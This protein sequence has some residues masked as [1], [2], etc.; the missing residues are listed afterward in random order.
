MLYYNINTAECHEIAREKTNDAYSAAIQNALI[1]GEAPVPKHED[2]V[3]R[4]HRRGK[5][6]VF[7]INRFNVTPIVACA[8]VAEATDEAQIWSGI[9][10]LVPPGSG[11][12][13]LDPLMPVSRPWL[14]FALLP[15]HIYVR[16]GVEWVSEFCSAVGYSLVEGCPVS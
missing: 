12:Y 1:K 13:R 2:F 15:G 8:F 16:E 5:N 6:A 11:F 7:T 10:R 14:A 4:L 3:L 9:I